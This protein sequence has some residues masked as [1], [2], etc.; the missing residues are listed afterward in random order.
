MSV[1]FKPDK[2]NVVVLS[3]WTSNSGRWILFLGTHYNGKEL[4]YDFGQFSTVTGVCQRLHF[5]NNKTG[6]TIE[7][8]NFKK[9]LARIKEGGERDEKPKYRIFGPN[10]DPV[11]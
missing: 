10:G 2:F 3:K 7:Y 6:A 9:S 1:T 5:P 11:S 4:C 8:D